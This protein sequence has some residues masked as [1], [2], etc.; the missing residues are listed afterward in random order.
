MTEQLDACCRRA[1]DEWTR[2]IRANVS[3]Y[4]VIQSRPCPVCKKVVKIRVYGPTD[5]ALQEQD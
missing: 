4:P 2:R 5:E 1:L 3:S